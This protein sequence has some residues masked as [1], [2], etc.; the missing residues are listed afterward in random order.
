MLLALYVWKQRRCF[1]NLLVRLW[2][3]TDTTMRPVP[4]DLI[5]QLDAGLIG[6]D[7]G[8]VHPAAVGADAAP[9]LD[10]GPVAEQ[11]LVEEDLILAGL[12]GVDPRSLHRGRVHAAQRR[13]PAGALGESAAVRQ[14]R[15]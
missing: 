13:H 3:R 15:V 2:W 4:G 10:Q 11:I 8:A 14:K 9:D 5:D 7:S 6:S 12:L 1:T